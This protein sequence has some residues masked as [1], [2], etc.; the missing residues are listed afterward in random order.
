M[1][2]SVRLLLIGSLAIAVTA[3]GA[4][5]FAVR[6]LDGL[7]DHVSANEGM[8][9]ANLFEAGVSSTIAQSEQPRLSVHG[10]EGAYQ[11]Y[12]EH[13]QQLEG[14]TRIARTWFSAMAAA[15]LADRSPTRF[16]SWI[17]SD[18]LTDLQGIY[19]Y[20]GWGHP[21]CIMAANDK[22]V[23]VSIGESKVTNF[24]CKQ[25]DATLGEI[26]EIPVGRLVRR[27]SGFLVFIG[28]ARSI[29]Q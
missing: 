3:V 8:Q 17:R 4:F 21:F 11:Y 13:P 6:S 1:R 25:V 5:W 23:V 7:I 10:G 9:L 19:R 28:H 2:K 22:A 29:K 24:D 26:S 12:R 14:D 20:D 27:S 16:T 15:E 18:K